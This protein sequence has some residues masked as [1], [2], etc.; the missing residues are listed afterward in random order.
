LKTLLFVTTPE[1]DAVDAAFLR[2]AEGKVHV[3]VL[4]DKKSPNRGVVI[5]IAAVVSLDDD[6][7]ARLC[8]RVGDGDVDPFATGDINPRKEAEFVGDA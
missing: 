8:F 4:I 3:A 7:V 2:A 5:D 1:G 6:E